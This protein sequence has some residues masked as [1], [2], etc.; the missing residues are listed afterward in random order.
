M[1][2][3]LFHLRPAVVF[4]RTSRALLYSGS[5]GNLAR[6]GDIETEVAVILKL[7]PIERNVLCIKRIPNYLCE[8]HRELLHIEGRS[9]GAGLRV[10]DED[11]LSLRRGPGIPELVRVAEPIRADAGRENH[12]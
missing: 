11:V 10:H 4:L 2:D 12:L 7:E 3:L 6:A 8:L 1:V 5:V 9:L